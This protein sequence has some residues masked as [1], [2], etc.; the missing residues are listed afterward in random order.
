MLISPQLSLVN[1][2]R[3]TDCSGNRDLSRLP[4]LIIG[5]INRRGRGIFEVLSTASTNAKRERRWRFC[6]RSRCSSV[7]LT[8]AGKCSSAELGSCSV[9]GTARSNRCAVTAPMLS[10]EWF[11]MRL[12]EW[13]S[14]QLSSVSGGKPDPGAC[15]ETKKA[16]AFCRPLWF[17]R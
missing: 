9:T 15:R 3:S 11:W 8:E 17:H 14:L 6:K 2:I 7:A 16:A 13:P 4:V 10:G 12:N 5:I 1:T